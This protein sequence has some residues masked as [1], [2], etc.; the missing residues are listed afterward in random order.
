MFCI[1]KNSIINLK[2]FNSS[3]NFKGSSTFRSWNTVNDLTIIDKNSSSK[4]SRKVY[5]SAVADVQR[6]KKTFQSELFPLENPLLEKLERPY[7]TEKKKNAFR[8]NKSKL[9]QK[10]WAFANLK[11]SKKFLAFYTI[12]FPAYTPD[13]DCYRLFNTWLT[14][15]RTEYSNFNYVWVCERQTGER[16][17]PSNKTLGEYLYSKTKHIK[18]YETYQQAIKF[19]TKFYNDNSPTNTLHF[20]L[21]TNRYMDIR[22]V[23]GY[24]RSSL[25]REQSKGQFHTAFLDTENYNGVD[26][27][28]IK[29]YTKKFETYLAKYVSKNDTICNRLPYHSSRLVSALF[30]KVCIRENEL[31]YINSFKSVQESK[32]FTFKDNFFDVKVIFNGLPKIL[33]Y[34]LF[35]LNDDIES[36]YFSP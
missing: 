16:K 18:D 32:S 27:A 8:L 1:G 35:K 22:T 7:L 11:S 36:Y 26:V 24:M 2:T 29:S 14:R 3:E 31:D 15:C 12:S 17:K 19:Y 21:I 9:K 23:N 33:F 28:H 30:T 20:H 4:E 25:K 6:N 5:E 10:I 13:D 34:S